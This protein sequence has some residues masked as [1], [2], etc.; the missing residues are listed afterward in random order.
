M[1][2]VTPCVS[3][4]MSPV[5]RPDVSLEMDFAPK[6]VFCPEGI[7]VELRSH[8][9]RGKRHICLMSS[10]NGERT[11]WDTDELCIST[12]SKTGIKFTRLH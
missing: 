10:N 8:F 5:T 3:E 12:F 1:L 4:S 6:F 7:Q 2:G 11:T 9:E